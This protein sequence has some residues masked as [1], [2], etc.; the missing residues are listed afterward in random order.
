MPEA[1]FAELADVLHASEEHVGWG[2]EDEAGHT[3]GDES[4]HGKMCKLNKHC[5]VQAG[6]KHDLIDLHETTRA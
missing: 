3:D 1:T 2:H 5:L 4:L 6:I